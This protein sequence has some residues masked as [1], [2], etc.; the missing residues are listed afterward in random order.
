MSVVEELIS[1]MYIRNFD[2]KILDL[3]QILMVVAFSFR[4][5]VMAVTLYLDY[6][7]AVEDEMSID[8]CHFDLNELIVGVMEVIS[9]LKLR[10]SC[11]LL[12]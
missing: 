7:A 9:S 12:A 2:A 5:N 8:R 6:V 3:L 1:M 10:C 4:D 11:L